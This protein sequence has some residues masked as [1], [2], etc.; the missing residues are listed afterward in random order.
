MR[1]GPSAGAALAV[2]R[3]WDERRAAAWAAG[4]PAALEELYA[5]GSAAGAED[6]RLVLV[7]TDRVAGGRAVGG[8][9]DVPLPGDRPT[10]R[11]VALV[12]SAGQ[13]RVAEV[14]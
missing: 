7:V 2:L 1:P 5:A 3:A 13:W 6:D 8:G 10:T 9:T 11:T 4:D 12:R 14:R